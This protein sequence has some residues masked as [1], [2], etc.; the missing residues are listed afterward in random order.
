M[1]RQ[2]QETYVISLHNFVSKKIKMSNDNEY[3]FEAPKFI[4]FTN[5]Q[6]VEDTDADHWFGK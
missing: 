3:E 6:D 1:Q 2:D 4:D 5:Q